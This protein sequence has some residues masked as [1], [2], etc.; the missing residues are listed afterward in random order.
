M[1]VSTCFYLHDKYV[2][3]PVDTVPSNIVF[4]CKPH[5][6]YCNP[7]YI[8]TTHTKKEIRDNHRSVLCS[9]EIATKDKTPDL[10]ISN[11]YIYRISVLTDINI[12]YSILAVVKSRHTV[13]LST[14]G[15]VGIKC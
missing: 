14:P 7:K 4:V 12:F 6:I 15:V 13:T 10:R 5:C 1:L 2:V 8:S 11:R 3:I 9:F